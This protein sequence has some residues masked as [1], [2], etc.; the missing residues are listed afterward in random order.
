MAKGHRS[1]FL[2]ALMPGRPLVDADR[3]LT[4]R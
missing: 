3:A 4:P 2:A 1:R